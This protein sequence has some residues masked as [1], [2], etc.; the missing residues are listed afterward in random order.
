MPA[1][2]STA[3]VQVLDITHQNQISNG[4]VVLS[5]GASLS[6]LAFTKEGILAALD[7]KGVLRLRSH[8]WGGSW[9]P[10]LDAATVK[11]LAGA[12]MYW[13][14]WLDTNNLMAVVTNSKAPYPQV[15]S[16]LYRYGHCPYG[17]LQVGGAMT[18]RL[19]IELPLHTAYPSS[20]SNYSLHQ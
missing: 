18:L 19:T 13:P 14:A 8:S 2:L 1:A 11:A 6:W 17:R 15:S 16:C 5:A 3:C 4:S 10:V 20:C 12:D 7:S 9:V